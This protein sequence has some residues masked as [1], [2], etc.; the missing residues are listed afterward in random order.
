MGE[1][2][3][4]ARRTH[5]QIANA[6]KKEA[7]IRGIDVNNAYNQFLREVFLNALMR[8]GDGWV[9]KGGTNVYCRIPGARH[10]KDLDLYRHVDPTSALS[11]AEL[12]VEVMNGLKEGPYTFLLELTSRKTMAGPVE[13]ERIKVIVFYGANLKFTEFNIDVSGDLEVSSPV[14]VVTARASFDV[15][16]DFLPQDY[17]VTAYPVENQIADKV[18]AMYDRYGDTSPGKAST[19]YHDFFDVALMATRLAVGADPL[20]GALEQQS[21]LRGVTLPDVVR[22]PEPGWGRI[23]EEKA[24]ALGWHED[25]LNAFEKA[26]EVTRLLLDPVLAHDSRVRGRVWDPLTSSWK[27]R[28]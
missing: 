3:E 6:L 23:Y 17:Q 27:P 15:R 21:R 18:A 24:A 4:R 12:L 19:R 7:R 8:L 28:N 11:A 22:E 14:E 20:R 1:Q 2:P 13:N 10:T 16:T 5:N 25:G 26:L 9:L